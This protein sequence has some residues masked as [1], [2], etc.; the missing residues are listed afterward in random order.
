MAR[1]LL[2]PSPR[3]VSSLTAT[4]E[5]RTNDPIEQGVGRPPARLG[6]TATTERRKQ[7]PGSSILAT[8]MTGKSSRTFGADRTIGGQKDS[9]VGAVDVDGRSTGGGSVHVVSGC[10]SR[11]GYLSGYPSLPLGIFL[12]WI[13]IFFFF[14]FLFCC[15][16][17]F[18][19]Y[20]HRTPIILGVVLV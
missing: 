10:R 1:R 13:I 16:V 19:S 20:F 2:H 15:C 5:G 8:A 4:G 11:L 9:A 6:N 14:S 3:I 7:I 18:L 17:L 12:L